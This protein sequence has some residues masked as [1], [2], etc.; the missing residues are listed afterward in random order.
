MNEAGKGMRRE[1]AENQ[2]IDA[3]TKPDNPPPGC[4]RKRSRGAGGT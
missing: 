2:L 3:S 1:V 4:V